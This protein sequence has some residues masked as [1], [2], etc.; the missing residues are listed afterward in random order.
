VRRGGDFSVAWIS[1][2]CLLVG[3][4]AGVAIASGD[5]L[6]AGPVVPGA[7]IVL[8]ASNRGSWQLAE[9][10]AALVMTALFF[11]A[12]ACAVFQVIDGWDL[13]F[14]ES[15]ALVALVPL[16]AKAARE[17]WERVRNA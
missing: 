7:I 1:V 4:G 17:Y 3:V 10:P 15:V 11:G 5:S 2:G 8:S 9:F 16:T 6:T 13:P 12:I 14:V